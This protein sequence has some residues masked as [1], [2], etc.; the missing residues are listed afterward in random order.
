MRDQTDIKKNSPL[1][2]DVTLLDALHVEADGWDGA[3]TRISAWTKHDGTTIKV[4]D[5]G[6]EGRSWQCPM[7]PLESRWTYSTVNSPP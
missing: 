2:G 7:A 4:R 1:E 6:G 5:G 3:M